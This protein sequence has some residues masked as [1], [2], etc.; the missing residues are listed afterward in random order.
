MAIIGEAMPLIGEDKVSDVAL[1]KEHSSW[2]THAS[3][4]WAARHQADDYA[5][6]LS[7]RRRLGTRVYFDVAE[8][9]D[10]DEMIFA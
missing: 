4:L 6:I 3:P 8:P 9:R 7:P 2:K 5:S 10:I 1:H